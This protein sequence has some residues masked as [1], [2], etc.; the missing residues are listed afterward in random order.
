[1][2][3]VAFERAEAVYGSCVLCRS[4]SFWRAITGVSSSSSTTSSNGKN[5]D[6]DGE[7]ERSW[8]SRLMEARFRRWSGLLGS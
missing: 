8:I 7:A 5:Y 6:G 2:E 3:I 4:A 1:M